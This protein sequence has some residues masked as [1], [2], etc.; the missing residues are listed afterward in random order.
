MDEAPVSMF[1]L[2]HHYRTSYDF[3]RQT[4]DIV[5]HEW[6][7]SNLGSSTLNLTYVEFLLIA[8]H[9]REMKTEYKSWSGKQVGRGHLG[10]QGINDNIKMKLKTDRI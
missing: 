5:W 7:Y 1:L 10:D 8:V 9:I 3:A 6:H 2:H 4:S